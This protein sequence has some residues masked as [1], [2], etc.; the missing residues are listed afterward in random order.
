MKD[1]QPKDEIAINRQPPRHDAGF[2]MVEIIVVIGIIGV[3]T[4][5]GAISYVNQINSSRVSSVTSIINTNLVQARQMA[6]AM[7][8]SR[9]VV[10]DPGKIEAS[11]GQR[12]KPARIWIEGK[13]CEEFNFEEEAFCTKDGGPNTFIITDPD[14]LPDGVSLVN[15]GNT[16][17]SEVN[18]GSDPNP[19]Y[20][21]FNPRGQL[22]K[23]YFE[24]GEQSARP[25]EM[26]AVFHLTR[27]NE[28]YEI[29]GKAF[30]Y[31]DIRPA[32]ADDT[33]GG[34]EDANV[35]Y[36]INTIEILWLTGKTRVYDYAVFGVWPTDLLE[37]QS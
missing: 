27:D 37:E 34:E 7:R 29:G 25:R 36:K 8:Q 9:R 11:S 3:L 23:I 35:R 28:T 33:Q 30:R 18:D 5:I 21:Q 26:P 12:T 15:V 24:G 31:E 17:V 16:L 20:I 10:I 19:L 32:V 14:T 1:L 13:V 2:S 22:S 4:S 6:I